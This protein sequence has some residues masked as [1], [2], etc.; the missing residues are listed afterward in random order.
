[1]SAAT[2]G[3]RFWLFWPAP[4]RVRSHAPDFFAKAADSSGVVIDCRPENRIKP[5]D[6]AAFAATERACAL[7]A[8]VSGSS[9][10]MTRCG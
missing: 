7:A 5:R 3:L 1:M 8:G 6:A 9:P 10:V 4:D 2:S